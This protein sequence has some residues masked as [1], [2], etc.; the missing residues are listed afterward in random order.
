MTGAGPNIARAAL[1]GT[2]RAGTEIVRS[3]VGNR[4]VRIVGA[5]SVTPAKA[6]AD[7]GEATI[8]EPLGVEVTTDLDALLARDDVEVILHSGLG[9]A[10]EVAEV[11]GRCA[12]AG[13]D[14]ITVSGFVHPPTAIGAAAAEDLDRRARE[15]GGRVV[16]T[17]VNPG[18]LLDVLPAVWATMA[19][20]VDHIN[21]R[22]ISDIRRWGSGVLEHEVGV[23]K[24]PE[25]VRGNPALSVVE[26]CAL[27][28]DALELELDGIE[29]VHDPLPSPNAREHEGR[30]VRPGETMGYRRRALGRRG[31]VIVAEIE[32]LAIYCLD[33]EVD[34]T[35]E[36][37]TVTITGENTIETSATGTF[38]GDPYPSTAAR[39]LAAIGP[40]GDMPPGLY[41][42]DQIPISR[43]RR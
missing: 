24:P 11:L 41:R 13:K 22:R 33:S 32:W 10:A 18:M 28:A 12:A 39:A 1:F 7:L 15:G 37:A 25:E 23:G 38:C 6:G 42:P 16:G 40:L 4:D 26:S 21:A 3:A 29:D 20:R 17:G 5:V 14:V 36:L 35:N 27:V 9:T 43:R 34:G 8:G 2:G 30:S 19:G 31:D